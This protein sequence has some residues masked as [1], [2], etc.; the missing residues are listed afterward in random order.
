MEKETLFKYEEQ[1]NSLVV[2]DDATYSQPFVNLYRARKI[3]ED[4]FNELNDT[5]KVN[6]FIADWFEENRENLNLAIYRLITEE[7][8]LLPVES[9]ST[10]FESWFYRTKD[11]ATLVK[12]L[13][14][15]EVIEDKWLIFV[16][17]EYITEVHMENKNVANL[18]N[19][20]NTEFRVQ[21]GS[22][23]QAITFNTKEDADSLAKIF[24]DNYEI[25]RGGINNE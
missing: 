14:G 17:G 20:L 23:E 2:N 24:F 8:D 7:Q 5:I 10:E 1:L 18:S 9:K 4:M 3:L 19:T 13:D 12:M 25:I 22:K 15:Y 11:I 21:L 6:Q 16:A